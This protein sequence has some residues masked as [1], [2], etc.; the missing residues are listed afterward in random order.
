[1]E[2]RKGLILALAI[3]VIIAGA[4]YVNFAFKKNANAPIGGVASNVNL[5]PLPTVAMSA[6]SGSDTGKPITPPQATYKDPSG[7]GQAVLAYDLIAQGG[8]F[9][10][11]EL[12]IAKGTHVQVN[13][14]AVDADYDL[15]IAPPIG[16]YL[17]AKKGTAMP[18][19]FAASQ[20]GRYEF[21]CQKF[22]PNNS[23]MKGV[24]IVK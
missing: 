6:L 12:I 11:S 9:S 8:A 24:L 4:L 7:K 18:F 15:Q 20:A 16:L 14:K 23:P 2:L 5:A 1:M 19:G 17:V 22:C 10:P 3:V 21:A 13:F